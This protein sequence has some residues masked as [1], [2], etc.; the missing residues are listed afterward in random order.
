M[1]FLLTDVPGA[2]LSNI[3]FSKDTLFLLLPGQISRNIS[4]VNDSKCVCMKDIHIMI[5]CFPTNPSENP[6]VPPILWVAFVVL[7]S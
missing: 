7:K 3:I 6:A 2:T 5:T 1:K 4:P